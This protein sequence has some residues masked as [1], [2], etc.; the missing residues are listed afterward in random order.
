LNPTLTGKKQHFK[1]PKQHIEATRLNFEDDIRPI[2]EK[3]TNFFTRLEFSS[4]DRF[5]NVC[6]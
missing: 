1:S 6:A 4:I 3:N 2:F 5:P